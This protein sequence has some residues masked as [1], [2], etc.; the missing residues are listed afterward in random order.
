MCANL[1]R[2]SLPFWTGATQVPCGTVTSPVL[3]NTI[4]CQGSKRIVAAPGNPLPHLLH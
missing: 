3:A 4:P 2:A 1:A